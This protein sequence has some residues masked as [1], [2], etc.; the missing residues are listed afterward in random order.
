MDALASIDMEVR[1]ALDWISEESRL[2]PRGPEAEE[3]VVQAKAELKQRRNPTSPTASRTLG[4]GE[5]T[6]PGETPV[7]V[8]RRPDG[9]LPQVV[10]TITQDDQRG[11]RGAR[12]RL[13]NFVGSRAASGHRRPWRPDRGRL[14]AYM[15]GGPGDRRPAPLPRRRGRH[16]SRCRTRE[17]VRRPEGPPAKWDEMAETW[18]D[19]VRAEFEEKVWL[20]LDQY[21]VEACGP[22]TGWPRS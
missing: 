13:R 5:G 4:P 22:S 14:H 21:T 6:G 11:V 12:R 17:A 18:S 19:N 10:G 20:P 7:P 8:R 2:A 1:R 15:A 3:D 16:E 9:R